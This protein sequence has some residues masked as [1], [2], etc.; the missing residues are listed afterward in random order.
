MN[1]KINLL[2]F[3]VN[4]TLLDLRPLKTAINRGFQNDTAFDQWFSLLLQY[5]WVETI[6]E[7][8]RGFGEIGKAVLEMLA[9]K[10]NKK[11]SAG[12]I[13]NI[14]DWIRK[15]PPHPDVVEGLEMLKKEG[16][17]MVVLTN[18]TLEV[19]KEQLKYSGLDA[20]FED[21][22]SVESVKNY[23]PHGMNYQKVLGQMNVSATEA[24]M[25]ACHA[26][27]ITGAQ[28]A[29]LQGCFIARPG[30]VWYPLENRPMIL[31]NTLSQAAAKIIEL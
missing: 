2:I 16:F 30:M 6:T 5:S 3:D 24:M 9:E 7:E 4:E 15:L 28:R 10:Q 27:D 13:E 23:K 20:Y 18:G 1:K 21:I 19:A 31:E 8:F 11:F 25:V 14:L 29:G 22:F 26:W 12:E 17:R